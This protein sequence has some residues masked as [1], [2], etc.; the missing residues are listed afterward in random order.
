MDTR[1]A[2]AL[3]A[4]VAACVLAGTSAA[5]PSTVRVV[6]RGQLV[7]LSHTFTPAT[8][9]ACVAAVQ[10]LDD[11]TAADRHQ[12]G[13]GRAGVV[14]DPDSPESGSRPRPL[15][16]SLRPVLADDRDLARRPSRPGRVTRSSTLAEWSACPRLTGRASGWPGDQQGRPSCSPSRLSSSSSR[17]PGTRR[18]PRSTRRSRRS[19]IASRRR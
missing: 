7:T 5:A 19:G 15:V 3:L 4:I 18:R 13:L 17:I 1:V 10:Y 6:H 8:T 12:A 9:V 16:D 11:S 14:L 2:V